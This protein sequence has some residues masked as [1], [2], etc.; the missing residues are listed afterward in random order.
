ML[1]KLVRFLGS[2]KLAVPVLGAIASILIWA[3]FYESKV[4]SLV[5]QQQI[6][7][8]PWFGALMFLLAVNLGVSTLSRYPWRGARKVGFALTHL[9]LIVLIAGSAAVIHLG[10]EGLLLV[11]TDQPA[12]HLVRVEGELLEVMDDQGQVQQAAVM[13]TPERIISP[14]QFA[15]L[16]LLDYIEN[17]VETV[18]Y[19]DG[20]AQDDPAIR[21]VL[22]SDR[23][24]QTFDQWLS[25]A[26]ETVDL[27][28]AQLELWQ[29]AN[30][31]DLQ[32]LLADPTQQQARQSGTL[33]FKMG[34]VDTPLAIDDLRRQDAVI[35]DIQV[36]LLN[37]WPDFRLDDQNQPITA[38]QDWR[39]PALEVEVTQADLQERWFVFA[40]AG[41]IL[42]GD[43]SLL[44]LDWEYQIPP[45]PTS[46]YF[47]VVVANQKLYY[48][49]RSSKSFTSGPLV[50]DQMIQPGWADFKITLADWLPHGKRIQE[51]LPAPS[52]VEGVP[53][54]QVA[55]ADGQ[56]W[57]TWGDSALIADGA[58][59]KMA[60]FG[61]RM[62]ALPFRVG[63]DDFVVE[64]N[65]GSDSVAMWTSQIRIEDLQGE[66]AQ[67]RSVWMNHPTW[68]Q[69][70]KIAQASWNPGDLNQSTL[71]VKREPLWVTALTWS[72]ALLTV[73]GVGVMFYGP[74]LFK[75]RSA[76][77]EQP[78]EPITAEPT[79]LPL[80][81]QDG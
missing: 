35:N 52:G 17:S 37:V 33:M 66:S 23:M 60:A 62:L 68:Y 76:V 57:L 69:G 31:T 71:Q 4:G 34:D 3:T 21:L 53:A 51:R 2:I 81:P 39:N 19:R 13:V 7:K 41:P 29:A 47:R 72:G 30:Q 78:T 27:G 15:G 67:K 44:D 77:L 24:G 70:W 9:G 12:N 75:K 1:T 26:A 40:Q 64:R 36:H 6:Y 79:P 38:S 49:A 56:Q 43:E 73:L 48:A 63:L 32:Q 74:T 18:E 8:S 58:H 80:A 61:P 10:V 50:M 55:S 28:P 20:D 45:P 5:V 16:R 22:S 11:R 46:D 42:A 54:L 65:E 14:T 25:P 59:P